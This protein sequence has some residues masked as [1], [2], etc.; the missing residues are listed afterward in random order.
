MALGGAFSYVLCVPTLPTPTGNFPVGS[1]QIHAETN[2]DDPF[3]DDP[4]EKRDL[5]VKVWYP[6]I[7]DGESKE[8]YLPRAERHGFA[9][10]YGLPKSTFSYLNQTKTHTYTNPKGAEGTF[11]VLIFSHGYYSKAS[12]YYSL[13]EEMASQGYIILAINHTGESTGVEFPDGR[14]KY[15]DIAFDQKNNNQEMAELAWAAD[16]GYKNA[17]TEQEQFVAVEKTLRNYVAAA[18]TKRWSLDIQAIVA[19]IPDWNKASFLK[20]HL[21]ESLIGVFG[22]S[23][24]GSAAGQAL[25]DDSRIMCGIN[26]DGVA[27]GNMLDTLMTK[28]FS[29]LSADWPASHPD[30]NKFAYRNGGSAGF[31]KAKI[32]GSAHSNFMD[33]PLMIKS[34]LL[35]QAGTIDPNRAHLIT[36]DWIV[37]FFDNYLKGETEDLLD[38]YDRYTELQPIE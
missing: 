13:L 18:T 22:H 23:Q 35:S 7:S 24:G 33:I 36:N 17:K 27:W 5:M 21:E 12:G 3:S 10:K 30:L 9:I 8:P 37:S 15:Y 1:Q 34:R 26:I 38:L 16:Q 4:S 25:V 14:I 19:R 31:Y 6:A 29:F 20:G 32:I 2:L 11:P 28:P